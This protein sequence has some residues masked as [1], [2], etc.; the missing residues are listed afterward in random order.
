[1]SLIIKQLVRVTPAT[2]EVGRD[3]SQP[4]FHSVPINDLK[5]KTCTN[6]FGNG[7]GTQLRRSATHV[8]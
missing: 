1:M 8:C 6:M 3:G 4:N 7:K 2:K 5:H